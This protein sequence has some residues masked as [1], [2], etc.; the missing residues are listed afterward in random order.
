MASPAGMPNP[1]TMFTTPAG[2]T[3]R[4]ISASIVA[5]RGLVSGGFSTT[6]LP[7]INGAARALAANLIGWLN[8]MMRPTTPNGS[9]TEKFT[10]SG[11]IGI[12]APFI[13]VTSPA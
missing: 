4:Q 5:E 11:P 10:T 13:S 6:Q 3:S 9:R 1:V 12:E 7:A 2:R 8:G